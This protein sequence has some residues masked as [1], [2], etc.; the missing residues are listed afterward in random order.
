MPDDLRNDDEAV[1]RALTQPPGPLP[2]PA[3]GP[4]GWLPIAL[5][6]LIGLAAIATVAMFVT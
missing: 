4:T 1:G 3:R 6:G 2:P 5:A